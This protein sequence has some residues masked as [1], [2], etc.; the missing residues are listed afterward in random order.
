[1]ASQNY[2]KNYL[3]LNGDTI[4]KANFKMIFNSFINKD[5]N[6]PLIILKK[7]FTNERYG[8]Y[9]NTNLGWIF[10]PKK[11]SYISMGAFLSHIKVSKKDG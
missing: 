7:S 1:M 10:F 2:S 5:E 6:S 8:G 3:V 11:T 9:E 4:F